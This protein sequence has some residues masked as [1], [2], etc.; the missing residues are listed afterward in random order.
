MANGFT[1][2]YLKKLTSKEDY[3]PFLEIIL[4]EDNVLSIENIITKEGTDLSNTNHQQKMNGIIL[5]FSVE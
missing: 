4:P 5:R 3:K 2:P 1:K